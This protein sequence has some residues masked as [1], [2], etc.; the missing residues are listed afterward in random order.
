MS[1]VS[2]S[3]LD[4]ALVYGDLF[5]SLHHCAAFC[6]PLEGCP[7]SS[8]RTDKRPISSGKAPPLSS[9]RRVSTCRFTPKSVNLLIARR[10]ANGLSWEAKLIAQIE[11][12][13]Q[14]PIEFACRL[15]RTI[16]KGFKGFFPRDLCSSSDNSPQERNIE[17]NLGYQDN[18]QLWTHVLSIPFDL[19]LFRTHILLTPKK[20]RYVAWVLAQSS[21]I[22]LIVTS[23]FSSCDAYMLI[24]NCKDSFLLSSSGPIYS[25]QSWLKSCL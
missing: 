20:S 8:G 7:R 22:A 5:S 24:R 10:G 23:L 4:T 21:F 18:A 14:S 2:T 12:R 15:N 1:R 9:S 13:G 3:N 17:F 25:S 19:S 11:E 16:V 6:S